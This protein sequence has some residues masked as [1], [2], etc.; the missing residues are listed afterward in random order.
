MLSSIERSRDA[1]DNAVNHTDQTR[2]GFTQLAAGNGQVA[3]ITPPAQTSALLGLP[4]EIL[5]YLL[6]Y[7][8][9]TATPLLLS[10]TCHQLRSIYQDEKLYT[11]RERQL[12]RLIYTLH[13]PALCDMLYS[14]L[15]NKKLS[16]INLPAPYSPEW[17]QL[18]KDPLPMGLTERERQTAFIQK[19]YIFAG[20]L[21]LPAA[22]GED[23]AH[24]ARVMQLIG[25]LSPHIDNV[26]SYAK[27]LF[28]NV[29]PKGWL[30]ELVAINLDWGLQLIC[31]HFAWREVKPLLAELDPALSSLLSE[32]HYKT[33]QWQ[34]SY[35]M[36]THKPYNSFLAYVLERFYLFDD[37]AIFGDYATLE[38]T[39]PDIKALLESILADPAISY[40]AEDENGMT[41]L[42]AACQNNRET[43]VNR[44]LQHPGVD[45][46]KQAS[47][48]LTALDWA[49][50]NETF[51][52]IQAL[53]TYGVAEST[54]IAAFNYAIKLQK[55]KIAHT[56]WQHAK[57]SH[58]FIKQALIQAVAAEEAEVVYQLIKAY[59][60][61]PHTLPSNYSVLNIALKKNHL[62][63]LDFLLRGLKFKVDDEVGKTLLHHAIKLKKYPRAKLISL[64]KRLLKSGADCNAIDGEGCTP[65]MLACQL[66]YEDIATLL[67]QQPLIDV[68]IQNN[69]R[70]ALSYA[71][72]YSTVKLVQALLAYGGV[73]GDTLVTAFNHAVS[74]KKENMIDTLLQY[75][76]Q[77]G[78]NNFINQALVRAKDKGQREV[79]N[80]LQREYGAV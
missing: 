26:A 27:Q 70:S 43:L 53:L 71:V 36:L 3:S 9:D 61:H 56:L 77:Q 31:G 47:T 46:D 21:L 78:N 79:I 76:I 48:G 39:H 37:Y 28:N 25:R 6:Q 20:E 38:F 22:L 51:T 57:S 75:A 2:G 40:N 13:I 10:T 67:L 11:V 65:L 34:F 64:I 59:H 17:M 50:K 73:E 42:I 12:H 74:F 63:L 35:S 16:G 55:D 8:Q 66:N 33:R 68:N 32:G 15:S 69:K 7:L 41:L 45:T 23:K 30:E 72:T 80:R 29:F 60:V 52:I 44:Y 1:F 4:T 58:T 18:R 14:Q 49:V 19:T 24:I 5:V 54:H 62:L